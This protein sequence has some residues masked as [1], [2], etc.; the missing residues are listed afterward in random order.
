MALAASSL[1]GS[2]KEV[3]VFENLIEK[4]R[5]IALV[6]DAVFWSD[7]GGG[8]FAVDISTNRT[9]T[10]VARRSAVATEMIITGLTHDK[11]KN[12]LFLTQ[13]DTIYS[14]SIAT[15][16]VV[17]I[18]KFG[19]MVQNLV[20]KSSSYYFCA[21]D[22]HNST[23]LTSSIKTPTETT[24]VLRNLAVASSSSFGFTAPRFCLDAV[25]KTLYYGSYTGSIFSVDLASKKATKIPVVTGMS[26]AR[27]YIAISL[28][29]PTSELFLSDIYGNWG[30]VSVKGGKMNWIYDRTGGRYSAVWDMKFNGTRCWGTWTSI[31]DIDSG[32]VNGASLRTVDASAPGV[33]CHYGTYHTG[34]SAMQVDKATC[35]ALMFQYGSTVFNVSLMH[36][37]L[38][39]L[40]VYTYKNLRFTK[41]MLRVPAAAGASADNQLFW[42]EQ[43]QNPHAAGD[44]GYASHLLSAATANLSGATE[45]LSSFVETQAGSM[46][47]DPETGDLV[48]QSTGSR[49]AYVVQ[50]YCYHNQKTDE[51]RLFFT[52]TSSYQLVN[53]AV[54]WAARELWI[55]GIAYRRN[56]STI[57]KVSLDAPAGTDVAKVMLKNHSAI[58]LAMDDKVQANTFGFLS[59]CSPYIPMYSLLV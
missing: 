9:T 5:A 55:S 47:A 25:G 27:T 32:S 33:T 31:S 59:F 24:V 4:P 52:Q 42:F 58:M 54:D 8:L 19:V 21:V 51:R 15:K 50:H 44:N 35:S 34:G 11:Q 1:E 29:E 6:D 36:A 38:P 28:H 45:V 12:A 37:N 22:K 3:A 46:F 14:M 16:K 57:R 49:M 20:L 39:E 43:Y 10:Y 2:P 56:E 18:A 30:R 41:S 48:Y 53:A 17:K 7:T 40:P 13:N 26:S 23:L